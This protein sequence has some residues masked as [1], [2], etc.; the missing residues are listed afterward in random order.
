[1]RAITSRSPSAFYRRAS[2]RSAPVAPGYD[3]WFHT[4]YNVIVI[5]APSVSLCLKKAREIAVSK[6]LLL[7]VG[8]SAALC[9]P[10]LRIG[11][12]SDERMQ[13]ATL[14][15]RQQGS[16]TP[17]DL[18]RF[19]SGNPVD[20][21]RYVRD[22]QLPWWANPHLK[23]AFWRPLSSVV[24]SIEHAVF[25]RNA[26]AYHLMSVLWWLGLIAVVGLFYRRV[27][28]AATAA[29]AVIVFAVQGVHWEPIAFLCARHFLIAAIPSTLGLMAYLRHREEGWRSGLP[30][31]LA[32]FVAGLS[33]GEIALQMLAFAL[34]Y[35]LVGARD[36]PAARLRALAPVAALALGYVVLH[37]AL[38]YGVQGLGERYTDLLTE[39]RKALG[40][41]FSSARMVVA[42]FDGVPGALGATDA[43]RVDRASLLYRLRWPYVLGVV[44][45]CVGLFAGLRRCPPAVMPEREIARVR[46]LLLGGL[47][48]LVPLVG[49]LPGARL[50]LIPSIGVTPTLVLLLRWAWAAS[51]KKIPMATL[52]RWSVALVGAAFAAMQLGV[53]LVLLPLNLLHFDEN[54]SR[55]WRSR[56]RFVRTSGAVQASGKDVIVLSTPL[57]LYASEISDI[58][59]GS[60]PWLV[61]SNAQVD[62]EILRTGP[63]AFEIRSLGVQPGPPSP[64]GYPAIGVVVPLRDGL[65]VTLLDASS[66]QDPAENIPR[67]IA[68]RSERQLD[69]P[70][71]CFLAWDNGALRRMQMPAIGEQLTLPAPRSTA[72][73]SSSR[74]ALP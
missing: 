52:A 47:L 45:G 37:K 72:P 18:W 41:A 20:I 43:F 33:A 17:F 13:L 29:A 49:A 42:L 8:L 25:G 7:A 26:M 56:E 71:L 58:L 24:F 38:G 36:S 27:L 1:M 63:G 16:L 50:L 28:T 67:R 32:G 34:A 54:L 57:M 6:A 15:G 65:E 5:V 22:G 31:A 10:A 70:S 40:G 66:G 69:D 21:A 9:L 44:M 2:S 62:Q 73:G 35:E 11:F 59:P 30:L 4:P 68:V 3:V 64:V 55:Y 53:A 12:Y 61:L 74:M 19:Y 23:M 14:E 46:W 39:P 60:P 51:V 48:A